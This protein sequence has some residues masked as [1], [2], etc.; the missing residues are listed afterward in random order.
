MSRKRSASSTVRLGT[1]AAKDCVFATVSRSSKCVCYVLPCYGFSLFGRIMDEGPLTCYVFVLVS[2]LVE[3]AQHA[4]CSSRVKRIHFLVWM[5]PCCFH[6]FRT[7][8][9]VD[10]SAWQIVLT[11]LWIIMLRTSPKWERS[12]LNMLYAIILFNWKVCGKTS[13]L[14][15]YSKV[16]T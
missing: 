1:V 5:C 11:S 12:L 6:S 15:K 8:T 14:R 4:E 10:L 9:L 2:M 3:T 13:E 16:Q 7:G